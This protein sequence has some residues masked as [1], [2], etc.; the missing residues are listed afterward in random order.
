M[1]SIASKP[2]W[3]AE[4]VAELQRGGRR[5]GLAS[6]LGEACCNLLLFDGGLNLQPWPAAQQALAGVMARVLVLRRR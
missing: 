4:V 3:P 1:Y 6:A 2:S 5:A